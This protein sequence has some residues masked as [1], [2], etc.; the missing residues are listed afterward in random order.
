MTT[1]IKVSAYR[2]VT[3]HLFRI[4]NVDYNAC[5]GAREL[6]SWKD[7]AA[8]VLD[9]AESMQCSRASPYDRDQFARAL[10]AVKA[11]LLN[12]DARLAQ[13]QV[14]AKCQS[15]VPMTRCAN[16]AKEAP[17]DELAK[18]LHYC[19]GLSERLDPGSEIPAGECECGAFAYFIAKADQ[20]QAALEI[21]RYMHDLVADEFF[22]DDELPDFKWLKTKLRDAGMPV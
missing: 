19:D 15:A 22:A 8:G 6:G 14:K 9:V 3:E 4:A 21:V 20:S 16:C 5:V 17:I 2:N 18:A 1:T 7:T 10:A 13:S 11:R 12:A